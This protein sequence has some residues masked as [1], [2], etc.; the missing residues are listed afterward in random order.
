M[1]QAFIEQAKI[2]RQP[3]ILLEG[4]RKVPEEHA[5]RLHALANFLAASLPDAVFRSG[6]AQGA[7]TFF[8]QG[9][10]AAN[11]E[12]LE[13][14][15]PY[16]N[17]GKQR[18]PPKASVFA[19]EDLTPEELKAVVDITLAASP[20]LESLI[21]AYLARGRNRVTVKAMYL[22]RDAFKIIGAESLALP[23]ADFAFFFVNQDNPLTGG[24][25]H[26]IRVCR[27]MQVP[28]FTQDDWGAWL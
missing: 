23:P 24:T 6:N 22:L 17:Q 2:M 9:L 16:P 21:R 18:I 14:I 7:D 15:L 19:L 26:T 25:G 4:T 20:E 8:F 27:A 12:R 11:P 1:K 3:V 28:V 13:Y 10:V 5:Q